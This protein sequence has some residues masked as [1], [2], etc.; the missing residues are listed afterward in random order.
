[1]TAAPVTAMLP[2][3]SA[4]SRDSRGRAIRWFGNGGCVLDVGDD[5][6][7]VF[8]G[9]MLIGCYEIIDTIE[10]DALI[11][12]V[13]SDPRVRVNKVADAFGVSPQTAQRARRQARAGGIVALVERGRRGAPLKV[14]AKLVERVHGMFDQGVG[15]RAAYSAV[16]KQVGYGTVQRLHQQWQNECSGAAVGATNCAEQQ[17]ALGLETPANDNQPAGECAAATDAIDDD[18]GSDEEAPIEA[19][20]CETAARSEST[21][22]ESILR[23]GRQVQHAGAW[24]VIAMLQT[25]GLYD[26]AER[27]RK[28]SGD[29]AA[30]RLSLD[31]AAIALTLGQRT[32]EGVRRLA[33]PSL[34]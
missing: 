22:E 25:F 6:F 17:P 8:V 27:L 19:T 21:L 34:T 32:V 3:V 10:R 5:H 31:A 26:V 24:I 9:G 11:V 2:E 15:V 14:T 29:A 18:Q 23:G 28:D 12:V 30:L 16:Q 7:E 1:M 33:T 13:S 20:L 4:E